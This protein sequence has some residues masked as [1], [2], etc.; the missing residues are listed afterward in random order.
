MSMDLA[1][2]SLADGVR[3]RKIVTAFGKG[4]QKQ[5]GEKSQKKRG[6]SSHHG[7]AVNESD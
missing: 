7:A 6:R 3:L 5:E 4:P 2:F 1:F